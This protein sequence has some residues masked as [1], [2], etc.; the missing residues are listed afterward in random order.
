MKEMATCECWKGYLGSDCSEVEAKTDQAHFHLWD[1]SI[2]FF[3]I[4]MSA[5]FVTLS[6][7]NSAFN[8]LGWKSPDSVWCV[9]I[10]M[11]LGGMLEATGDIPLFEMVRFPP[12]FI[13]LALLPLIIFDAGYSL[14]K[15]EFFRNFLSICIFAILGTV[16]STMCVG[17]LVYMMHLHFHTHSAFSWGESMAFGALISA[18]DPVATLATFKALRVNKIFYM[19]VL[20]ESVMNDAISIA[21]FRRFVLWDADPAESLLVLAL[22][23]SIDFLGA[24]AVGFSMGLMSALVLKFVEHTGRSP[25]VE[26]ALVLLLAIAPY[27]LGEALGLS[28]VVAVLFAAFAMAHYTHFNLSPTAQVTVQHALRTCAYLSETALFLY[29]GISSVGL[30]KKFDWYIIGLAIGFILLARA[31]AIFP[32]ATLS[33]FIATNKLSVRQMGVM[34]FSGQRGAIAFALSLTLT[35]R[36][37]EVLQTTTLSLVLFTV[38]GLGSGTPLVVRCLLP[39]GAGVIAPDTPQRAAVEEQEG[40][41]ERGGGTPI[42]LRR[43]MT[44]TGSAIGWF[45]RIDDAYMKPFF[46]I[47]KYQD[48]GLSYYRALNQEP[49]EELCELVTLKLNKEQQDMVESSLTES[50]PPSPGYD[51]LSRAPPASRSMSGADLGCDL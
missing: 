31:A 37:A 19:M 11:F 29:L 7:I 5:V 50:I 48:E 32:L 14:D 18:T 21:L 24:I 47:P 42:N 4:A 36:G 23:L 28:G 30:S 51:S 45:E 10:G 26:T 38:L 33:N 40:L 12:E 27:L 1:Q 13:F 22:D 15:P 35:T 17:Q 9:L 41:M 43:R 34:W 46:R 25:T 44:M 2:T 8:S 3:T 16:I 39:Q 49:N 20:G 6:M